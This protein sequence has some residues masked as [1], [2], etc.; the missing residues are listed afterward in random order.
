[1]STMCPYIAMAT[2]EKG[3]CIHMRTGVARW[4][5]NLP[6]D[7]K[8]HVC[9]LEYFCIERNEI[10][11]CWLES[12]TEWGVGVEEGI[13]DMVAVCRS[14]G[15]ETRRD[16]RWRKLL[17]LVWSRSAIVCNARRH[18]DVNFCTMLSRAQHSH[19]NAYNV[20]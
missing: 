12:A 14:T 5:M 6:M 9:W 10:D 15:D 19:Y 11:E 3:A 16:E 7:L 8:L 20:L 17:D 13:E 1:V 18:D 4:R 2:N